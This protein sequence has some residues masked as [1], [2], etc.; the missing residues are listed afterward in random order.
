MHTIK[1]GGK[2]TGSSPFLLPPAL[3]GLFLLTLNGRLAI[4]RHHNNH[5][6]F[7]FSCVT[8]TIIKNKLTNKRQ[9][10]QLKLNTFLQNKLI[11]RSKTLSFFKK[12]K[13]ACVCK[14]YMLAINCR[15]V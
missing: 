7:S 3:L 2:E 5:V 10:T 1:G 9:P 6:V 13:M 11:N 12:F 4:G 8:S 15:T 14:M